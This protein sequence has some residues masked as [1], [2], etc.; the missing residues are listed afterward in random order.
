MS[1][2]RLARPGP[3]LP[4]AARQAALVLLLA[5]G[6]TSAHEFW[7]QPGSFAASPGDVVRTQFRVGQGWPGEVYAPD[8]DRVLRFGWIDA[9]GERSMS[10]AGTMRTGDEGAAWAVYRSNGAALTLEAAV[11]ESYLREEGLESVIDARRLRDESDRPGRE[12]YSRCAKSLLR[13]G[14]ALERDGLVSRPV[15]LTL[16]LVPRNAERL[17][18]GEGPFELQL[19]Y[20]GQPLPAAL[21]RALPRAGGAVVT[22]R[23]DARGVAVLH[24]PLAGVWLL[25]AV[26]MVRADPRLDADWESIWSSLTLEWPASPAATLS[27]PNGFRH[28]IRTSRPL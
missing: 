18:A 12:I 19:L 21:V 10:G 22:A 2:A 1:A 23:T 13:I 17:A 8:P 5:A 6:S 16:E 25:N 4:G 24:L 11:F 15:G 28:A 9:Q 20:L 26:H 3:S 14:A 27:N 7:L